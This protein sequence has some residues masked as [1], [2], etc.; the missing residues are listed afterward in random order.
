M[1]VEGDRKSLLILLAVLVG[2]SWS[3]IWAWQNSPYSSYLGHSGLAGVSSVT[4]LLSRGSIFIVG[5]SLMIFAMMLPTSIPFIVQLRPLL[6][7]SRLFATRFL[8]GYVGPW[9]PFGLL[10]YAG[11]WGLHSLVNRSTWLSNNEW[12][13]GVSTLA[14]A[15]IYQFTRL[16]RRSLEDCCAPASSVIPGWGGR[17]AKTFRIG[18]HHGI[19]TVGNSWA[20]ML[21]MFAFGLESI[22][23]MAVLLAVMAVEKEGR[24]GRRLALPIGAVLLGSATFLSLISLGIA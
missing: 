9:L 16:K 23:W 12:L 24:W 2:L 3:T 4:G 19:S 21:L 22:A 10:A 5:W 15:G 17:N 11:D 1:G 8:V 20:M 13:I 14:L 6:G 18:A 7:R